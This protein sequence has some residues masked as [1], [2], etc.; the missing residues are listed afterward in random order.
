MNQNKLRER[1]GEEGKET[2]EVEME[3]YQVF[4]EKH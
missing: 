1:L 3:R 2:K 4:W